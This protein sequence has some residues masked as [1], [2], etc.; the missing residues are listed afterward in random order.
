MI[1]W[2]RSARTGTLVTREMTH[3]SPPRLL[4]M[5]DTHLPHGAPRQAAVDLE[6][7][8]A[9]AASLAD[10]ALETGLSVGIVAWSGDWVMIPPNRGKRHRRDL[11]T[12][13][14]TLPVNHDHDQMELLSVPVHRDSG[15]TRTTAV[16]MTRDAL[17]H[18]ESLSG[19]APLVISSSDTQMVSCFRFSPSV[20]FAHAMPQPGSAPPGFAGF[21]PIP[22]V[23][24]GS[25]TAAQTTAAMAPN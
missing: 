1:Y 13:L 7:L 12:L 21:S 14:A 5:L 8:V 11:L 23:G 22:T 3:M 16:L 25:A 18:R 17:S 24:N 9:M 19:A 10:R 2:R 6:K 15:H 4:V 20:D